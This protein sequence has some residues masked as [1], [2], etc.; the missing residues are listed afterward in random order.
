MKHFKFV[1]WRIGEFVFWCHEQVRWLQKELRSFW[2]NDADLISNHHRAVGR[3]EKPGGERILQPPPPWYEYFNI[4]AKSLGFREGT[5][6]PG[7]FGPG[8]TKDSGT[9]KHSFSPLIV[10]FV[11]FSLFSL[12]FT[13][14]HEMLDILHLRSERYIKNILV[15]ILYN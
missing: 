2:G 1:N 8:S 11:L 7:S 13:C 9:K 14:I 10:S 12:S 6:A 15:L 3:S 5:L 4:P